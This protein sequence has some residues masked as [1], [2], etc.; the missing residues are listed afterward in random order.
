MG[1][2]GMGMWT[3]VKD[4]T[5]PRSVRVTSSEVGTPSLGQLPLGGTYTAEHFGHFCQTIFPSATA[6]KNLVVADPAVWVYS[7]LINDSK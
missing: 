3:T 5:Q 7:R 2:P 1:F 4:S 6:S